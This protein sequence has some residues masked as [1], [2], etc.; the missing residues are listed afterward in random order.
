MS[1]PSPLLAV[2]DLRVQFGTGPRCARVVDGVS[3]T[4]RPGQTTAIVG[5]SG[6]GKS[7]TVRAILGLLPGSARVSGSVLFQ[8]TELLGLSERAMRPRRGRDFAMIFQDPSRA[9]DPTMRVGTQIAEAIRVHEDVSRADAQARAVKL[10]QRVRMPSAQQRYKEYPHQL[11][12]GMR[13]R[14][15]I[16]MALAG[17]PALLIADEATTALDVTT[18]AQIMSLLAELQ[19]EYHMA[20]LVITHDMRLAASYSSQVV[21]MY[22]GRVVERAS[23]E[24][25]FASVRMPYTRAL[26]D[27]VPQLDSM[28]HT[29]LPVIAGRSP[30]LASL[31]AGC[32]FE[33][34]C[35]RAQDNCRQQRPELTE[36]E[37]GHLWS[38]FHP[39]QSEER[40]RR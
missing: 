16:A 15:M 40:C 11:S 6:S 9:L 1:S 14:V 25:L 19:A 13:Q 37:P 31:T 29:Q 7:V 33:P 35:A 34:R 30:V 5:E 21:V 20:M 39:M 10:L 32:A 23:T 3:F 22:A 2:K 28:P 24:T 38:C 17:R 4:V 36:H 12:G 27:A 18:Q 8:G 26:L